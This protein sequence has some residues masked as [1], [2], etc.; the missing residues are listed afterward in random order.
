M[1]AYS[2]SAINELGRTIRGVISAE[3]E[4]DLE[5]RLRQAGLD[6][7]T[8]K[9]VRQKKASPFSKVKMRDLI[10]LCLHL[11]QL[12]RAGVPLHESL[13]DIRDTTESEK[14]RDILTGV[15][16]SIKNGNMLSVAFAEH[17]KVFNQVFVGLLAAGEKTGRLSETF[18]HL[19][20]HLK[21]VSE[22]RRK[23]TKAIRYPIALLIIISL[24][25]AT[26]MIA[27]VPKIVAF[28]I[29][30]GFSIPMHTRALIFT[31]EV[32]QHYW[33]LVFGIPLGTVAMIA[34]LYRKFDEFAYH[35]DSILL[36]TPYIGSV[37]RKIDMA[38]FTHFFSVMFNSGIDILDSL[39]AARNV[40]KNRVI[41]E[42]IDF[43]RTNVTEGNSLTASLRLSNQ[44]P[45]L[46]IRM[47]KVGED[48][49][50]MRDS[51]ENVN[52]FYDREVNDAVEGMIG[53]IQPALTIVMGAMIF[54]IIAAVFGPLYESLGKMKF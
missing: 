25:I 47:F 40:V 9:A 19:G 43:V 36:K 8:A 46:V 6:L 24:V 33:Y 52:F 34:V 13:A 21:W 44:F 1:E 49:G 7:I 23:I 41:K 45:S 29:A 5:S 4:L 50:N 2:Y 11:E 27:V 30:Q 10:V 12:D 20:E 31:S 32:F 28:I 16:E 37:I 39:S 26:L 53:M 3:N 14:L 35:I 51:L 17:P 22:I 54:W 42:S 38:R 18:H 48:S 15:Y